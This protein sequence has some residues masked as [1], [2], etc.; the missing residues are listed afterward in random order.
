MPGPL[1]FSLR[2]AVLVPCVLLLF[3]APE[4]AAA[5]LQQAT[6]QGS[7]VGPGGGVIDHAVVTL[8]DSRGEP[9]AST[10][11]ESG[12]FLLTNVPPGTYALRAEALP[13]RAFLPLLRVTD[14]LPI[15]LQLRMSAVAEE[16]VLVRAGARDAVT[17]TAGI[18]LAGEAIRRAPVRLRSRALQDAIATTPGWATEDNGL[19]HVRGVDDGFL[20][21]VDGVPVYERLDGLFGMAPDP[22]MIDSVNVVTGYIPVEFGLKSGGV[23][24]VRSAGRTSDSWLGTLEAGAGTEDARDVSTV[25]GGPLGGVGA[26]TIGAAAQSSSRFLDPVHPGNLHNTGGSASGGAQFGWTISP[27]SVL[28]LVSAVGRSQFDVPHGAE[29]EMAGQDQR[30]RIA[31]ASQTASWQHVWAASTVSQ[32]AGYFRFG[33]SALF[34]GD[35]DTP[36]LTSADRSLVRTGLLASITHQRG[37]HLLKAGVEAA[38]LRLDEEF[39]FAVTDVELAEEAGLSDAAIEFTRARPFHFRGAATP[40]LFSV[41]LQD[42]I[43]ATERLTVDVGV[44]A[45]WIRMLAS[46]SQVSPRAGVSYHWPDTDTTL[47]GA[48]GRFF[49]PPQAEN[50]LLASSPAARTLSPFVDETDGGGGDVLPERQTAVDLSVSQGVARRLRLD[51]SYWARR[52]REAADPNVLFGTTIVFPNNVASGRAS[53]VDVR[54]EVPRRQ[55]W[56]GFVSY[57]NAHVVQFGPITGGLFLEDEVIEIGPGTRFTPDHDQRHVG[58]FGVSY[59]RERSGTSVSL[60]GRYESGT[61][62]EVEEDELLELQ[63]RPG[64]ELV[65]FDRGR[66]RPRQLFDA[67]IVQRLVRGSR[68]DVEVRAALL[69]VTGR[70]WAYNFGNPFSGTHFGPGRTI[71]IGF[72]AAFR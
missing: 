60:G 18:T 34:P 16:Q 57:A 26:V 14:A 64:A 42:S 32:V 27:A 53:G 39:S 55:G 58:A 12:R 49:Q 65:D 67:S 25:L 44:R 35:N 46:A 43:R 20:Y 6:I 2:A 38:R 59:D 71:Q 48:V 30:Q 3:C 52:V 7:L 33:S 63:E 21:V 45:D 37:A 29:Q 9:L 72:R 19:L 61:P 10:V 70:R 13:L 24:E 41:Y 66:V 31:N 47:R 8:L 15:E 69:N 50:L 51:V 54:L 4:R 1:L 11:A 36:L 17:P 68:V 28:T 23:I 56:S 62:L 40:T 22:A 5:Q